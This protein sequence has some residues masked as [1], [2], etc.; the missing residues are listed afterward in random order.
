M[1]A[2]IGESKPQRRSSVRNRRHSS[3]P[4]AAPRARVWLACQCSIPA[5]KPTHSESTAYSPCP[6]GGGG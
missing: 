1:K 2:S 4:V 5:T 3:R 6:G